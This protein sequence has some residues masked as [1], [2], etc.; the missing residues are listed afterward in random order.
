MVSFTI[1]W[2]VKWLTQS[3][4]ISKRMSWID[5]QS[6][7]LARML[8]AEVNKLETLGVCFPHQAGDKEAWSFGV[9]VP[10]GWGN[11]GS[12]LENHPVWANTGVLY[13]PLA[14]FGSTEMA[15]AP[16]SHLSSWA[17]TVLCWTLGHVRAHLP[18]CKDPRPYPVDEV[19]IPTWPRAP[20]L[21]LRNHPASQL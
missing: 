20:G 7:A 17:W 15:L 21:F 19:K 16:E 12:V 8:S 11:R 9:I 6:L 13:S 3:H 5:T 1:P 14:S 10:K 2:E 4:K 18:S